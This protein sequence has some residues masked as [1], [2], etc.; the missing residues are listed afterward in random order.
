VTSGRQ[1]ATGGA[2]RERPLEDFLAALG[3]RASVVGD[4]ATLVAG[5]T[6]DSRRVEQGMLFACLRGAHHDGHTH[7]AAAV[8]AG[9]TALL[10]DH[11]VALDVPQ[12]VVD[13]TR[14]ALGPVAAIVYG[15]PSQAL[16]V[17]GITGTNGK[18]TTAQLLASILRAAGRET[19][20]I[21]TLT[22]AHT[23]PEAP[24]LQAQLA[25]ARDDGTEAVVMEVSSHALALHR[26]DGTRFA[27]AVFTNLGTDHLDLHG[28]TEEYF[29][30]KAR[31][32]S[33]ELADLGVTNVDDRHGRLLADAAPIEI[34]PYSSAHATDVHVRA[35]HHAFSWREQ[36][37]EVPLGGP[38]NVMNSVA[39]ATTAAALGI[40]LD[41][42]ATGL[43]IV[44]PVP[45]RF[46]RVGATT[47]PTVLVDYAHTP[48][49]LEQLLAAAR[50]VAPGRVVVVFGCGG[51]RDA[52]KRPQMGAVAAR[53]A[54]HVVVTSD[55]PRSEDPAA[56]IS[57]VLDGI[58][59]ADPA[60]RAR[61]DVEPDRGAAIALAID[62]SGEGDVVVIAGK[63][64]ETTQTIG[65]RVRP[66]DD[67]D[68][69]RRVLERRT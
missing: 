65:D 27:A 58:D 25:A 19:R 4:P 52:G 28:T 15:Q 7:A 59:A 53:L 13:D 42:I 49:S 14:Q 54:D 29:R 64:H 10:V 1:T 5:V 66:F 67:R 47:S 37:L 18:T 46:E 68:V 11:E 34:V 3:P 50:G 48:D 21:G 30:A 51:D 40:P 17:I 41:A 9:A 24:E 45:G 36:R 61:I 31:L 33:P 2:R 44:E 12:V 26:A 57:A 8:A 20:V 55:N 39:A 62:A 23:T 16:T 60:M 35:D 56:I 6:H 22:G 32:F 38:F 63:G 43:A 69:A